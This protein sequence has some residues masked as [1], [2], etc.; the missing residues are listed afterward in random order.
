[1]ATAEFKPPPPCFTTKRSEWSF[2]IPDNERSYSKN[3]DD[4]DDDDDDV[5]PKAPTITIDTHFK[6]ITILRS[7]KNVLEHK[8]ELVFP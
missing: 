3:D 8:I 7:F 2:E 1:M 6:G 4:D 5:I